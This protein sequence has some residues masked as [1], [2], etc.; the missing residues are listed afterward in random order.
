[1]AEHVWRCGDAFSPSS[2][3]RPDPKKLKGQ[4]YTE[5]YAYNPVPTTRQHKHNPLRRNLTPNRPPLCVVDRRQANNVTT[6]RDS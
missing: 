6:I 2:S 1:M 3:D 5:V 4:V